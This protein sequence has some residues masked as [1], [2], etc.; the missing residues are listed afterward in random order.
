MPVEL[1][2]A[3]AER[4]Q[5][6]GDLADRNDLDHALDLFEAA[7]PHVGPPSEATFGFYNNYANVLRRV[8][9]LAAAEDLLRT[10]VAIAPS[11]WQSWHNLGQTLKD[12]E[13]YDEAA[14]TLRRAVMLEPG[15]GPNHGVLGEVLHHL[16]RLNSASVSLRRAI[17]LGCVD[18]H[19]V[20]TV[21]GNNERML[22]H[23]DDAL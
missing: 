18:D 2:L 3:R 22:G 21:L 4:L 12:L 20:W 10:L 14:A 1:L 19:A 13:R 6:S 9:R 15:F 11:T 16:G 5:Q 23:L 8:E 17:E 7:V